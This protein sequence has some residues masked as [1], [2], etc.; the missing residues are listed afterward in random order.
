MKVL[1]PVDG[2]DFTKRMLGYLAAHDDWLGSHHDY[3][4]MHVVPLI[5]SRAAAAL[6]KSVLKAHYED[7]AEKVFKPIRTFFNRQGMKARFV[8]KVGNAAELI[9]AAADKDRFDLVIMGSHGHGSLV[10][11][12]LGSVATKVIAQC[13]APVLLVR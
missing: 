13:K 7:T 12:V 8:G 6:D 11:L 9:S 1:V 3:T 5:P 2:S 4:I 10:N